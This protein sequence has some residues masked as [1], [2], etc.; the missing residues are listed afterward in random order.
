MEYVLTGLIKFVMVDGSAY[1]NFNCGYQV[2]WATKFCTLAPNIGG[3]WIWL[4]LHITLMGPRIFGW[5]L[6]FWNSCGHLC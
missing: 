2:T 4:L 1:I 5:L 3:F 6:D